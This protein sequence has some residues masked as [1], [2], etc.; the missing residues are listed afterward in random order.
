M[1]ISWFGEKICLQIAVLETDLDVKEWD[2]DLRAVGGKLD[3]AVVTVQ[4]VH[5]IL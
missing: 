4:V 2:R 3:C 1:C 5:K